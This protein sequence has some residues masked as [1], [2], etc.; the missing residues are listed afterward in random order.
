MTPARYFDDSEVVRHHPARPRPAA[1]SRR[2]VAVRGSRLELQPPG[3]A[4]RR[5]S[6]RV[7]VFP[8][9]TDFAEFAPIGGVVRPGLPDWLYVGRLVANKCQ[10]RWS[11]VRRLQPDLRPEGPARADRGTSKCGLR[12]AGAETRPSRSGTSPT[13]WST[14]GR[15][16]TTR[17][18]SAFAG[19]GVFVSLSEHEGFGVPILEAMAAR[20]PVVAFGRRAVPE[21]MGGAGI[22]LATRTRTPSPRPSRRCDRPGLRDRLVARQLGR[23]EQVEAFDVRCTLPYHG[24]GRRGRPRCEV[25]VQ[26]PFETSYSLA[27]V[28]REIALGLDKLPDRGPVDLRHRGTRRLRARP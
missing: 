22:L 25:Q 24:Q 4:G 12:R 16:P 21:T 28:N 27:V 2:A 5:V 11:G 1:L 7:D 26:G 19:A 20:V 8:V 9:R 13:G 17:T 14:R 18:A 6:D 15:C 10:H 23:V 3:D